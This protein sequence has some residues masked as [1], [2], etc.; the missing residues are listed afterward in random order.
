MM[1][2]Q[3]DVDI[4]MELQNLLPSYY[5]LIVPSVVIDELTTLKKKSKGK[6]KLA[7]SI[8]YTIANK[9]PFNIVNIKKT[10]HV[11]NLL[12]KFCNDTDVLCTNDK[13]LR[14]RARKRN[15]TVVYLRQHRYL[16]VDGYIKTNSY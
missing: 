8:A 5:D 2:F 3:L 10:D 4:V 9:E 15:I 7:A 12:L 14:K 11:D 13:I 16:E 6:N 1:M